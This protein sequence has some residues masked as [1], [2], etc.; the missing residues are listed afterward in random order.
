VAGK[1]LGRGGRGRARMYRPGCGRRGAARS[2][3]QSASAERGE[4][5]ASS[6]GRSRAQYRLYRKREGE[7][8]PGRGRWPALAINGGDQLLYR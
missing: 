5:W 3:E 1:G 7:G 2:E 8:E 4:A 6:V